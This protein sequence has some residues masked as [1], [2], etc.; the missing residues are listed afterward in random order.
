MLGAPAMAAW[1]TSGW[2]STAAA[3]RDP[4]KDHPRMATRSRSRNGNRS[5]AARRASTW[6]SSAGHQDREALIGEPLRLEEPVPGPDH[7]LEPRS[8]VRIEEDRERALG[9][10]AAGE[11]QGGPEFARS[12]EKESWL[13][14]N[15]RGLLVGYYR[16]MRL[17]P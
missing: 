17:P 14:L 13:R 4:P 2:R 7:P 1:N 11:E 6:S 3:A 10:P 8:A 16:V 12:R 5:A 9:L 15:D